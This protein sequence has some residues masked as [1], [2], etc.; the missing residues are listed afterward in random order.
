MVLGISSSSLPF[1][2]QF[3]MGLVA[4]LEEKRVIQEIRMQELRS[5]GLWWFSTLAVP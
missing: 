2:H 1:V 5:Q 3:G 4:G